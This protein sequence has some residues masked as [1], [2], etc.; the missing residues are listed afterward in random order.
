MVYLKQLYSR[1]GRLALRQSSPFSTGAKPEHAKISF[2]IN[3]IYFYQKKT[4][5]EK[6]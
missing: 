3:V 2:F 4:R 1:L 5:N 6:Y